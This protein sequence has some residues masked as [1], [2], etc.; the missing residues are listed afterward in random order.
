MRVV[1]KSKKMLR[2]EKK[3][4]ETLEVY[5]PKRLNELGVATLVAKELGISKATLSG[6][7]WKFDIE[8]TK[9]FLL[10]GQELQVL[11]APEREAVER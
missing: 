5:L 4:R 6:W 11:N 9:R 3:V 1:H 10:P 7:M 8:L 2:V